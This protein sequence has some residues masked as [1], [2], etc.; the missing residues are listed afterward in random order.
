MFPSSSTTFLLYLG[1]KTKASC[2]ACSS[3]EAKTIAP[4]L[5]FI[6]IFFVV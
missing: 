6:T 2:L 5:G 4:F 3:G 1:A